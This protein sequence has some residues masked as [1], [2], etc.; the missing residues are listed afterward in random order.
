[1][2]KYKIAVPVTEK[3]VTINEVELEADK[4][5]IALS[6]AMDMFRLPGVFVGEAKIIKE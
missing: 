5:A 6:M 4:E 3:T 2:N 1:M